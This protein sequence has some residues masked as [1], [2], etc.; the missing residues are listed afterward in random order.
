MIWSNIIWYDEKLRMQEC[1]FCIISKI[2]KRDEHDFFSDKGYINE[3]QRN[4]TV[5]CIDDYE[6][7][8]VFQLK[9]LTL[10]YG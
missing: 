4:S 10:E 3:K 2:Y 1:L 6:L 5:R 8:F 9:D 7:V